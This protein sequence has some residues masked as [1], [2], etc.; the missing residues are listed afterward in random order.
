LRD[1]VH[2][3]V[4]TRRDGAEREILLQMARGRQ[5]AKHRLRGFVAF[6]LHV[7]HDMPAVEAA[8]DARGEPPG[9]RLCRVDRFEQRVDEELLLLAG[10]GKDVDVGDHAGS[11]FDLR[12]PGLLSIHHPWLRQRHES[13]LT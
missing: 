12:H 9:D 10:D 7:V 8:V 11:G 13:R 3:L 6:E 4:L 5:V 2:H 1:G